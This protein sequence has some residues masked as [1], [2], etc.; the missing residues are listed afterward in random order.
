MLYQPTGNVAQMVE[1]WELQG[2]WKE[3]QQ[4][5]NCVSVLFCFLIT[6]VVQKQ[7]SVYQQFIIPDFIFSQLLPDKGG[8][9]LCDTWQIWVHGTRCIDQ[10]TDICF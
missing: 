9:F 6:E 7:C 4:E 3:K 5:K 1:R 2:G 8:K 10:N